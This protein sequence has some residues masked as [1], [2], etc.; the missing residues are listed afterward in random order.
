MLGRYGRPTFTK[1]LVPAAPNTANQTMLA[2][3]IAVIRFAVLY[4]IAIVAH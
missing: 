1:S 4:A 3:V 2:D